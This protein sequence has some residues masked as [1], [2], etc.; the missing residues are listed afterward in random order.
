MN[1]RPLQAPQ[2]GMRKACK[3]G[4]IPD[5]TR[6]HNNPRF[7]ARPAT[8]PSDTAPSSEL[9]VVLYTC[10][11]VLLPLW[12]ALEQSRTGESVRVQGAHAYDRL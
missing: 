2:E 4:E 9:S 7:H 5:H 10:Y 8:S 6:L 12:R 3:S 11:K 1:P